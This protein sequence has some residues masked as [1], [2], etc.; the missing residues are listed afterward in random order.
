LDAAL[1][2]LD[3]RKHYYRESVNVKHGV[4]IQALL[5]LRD[6]SVNEQLLLGEL[7]NNSQMIVREDCYAQGIQLQVVLYFK[8]GV[9][10][11]DEFYP[12][13][14]SVFSL[15]MINI[16]FQKIFFNYRKKLLLI[17]FRRLELLNS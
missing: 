14:F 8:S 9:I 13:S 15:N 17:S 5:G 6:T 3:I 11:T 10:S 7:V 12:D 4:Q 16:S 2:I 1:C